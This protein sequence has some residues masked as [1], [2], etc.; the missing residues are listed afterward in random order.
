MKKNFE[1]LIS[2]HVYSVH[3]S[4]KFSSAVSL[5]SL[6]NLNINQKEENQYVILTN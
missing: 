2:V 6:Y 3:L 1:Q 4:N 5:P